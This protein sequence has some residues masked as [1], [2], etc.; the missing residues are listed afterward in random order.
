MKKR[1]FE[2]IYTRPQFHWRLTL[3]VVGLTA[4]GSLFTKCNAQDRYL[5]YIGVG[6]TLN[7][8]DSSTN[9]ITKKVGY[10]LHFGSAGVISDHFQFGGELQ[11]TNQRERSTNNKIKTNS[12]AGLLYFKYLPFKD[13]GFFVLIGP[14]IGMIVNEKPESE[15]EELDPMML[16][17]VFGLGYNMG[18]FNLDI[19]QNIPLS[20]QIMKSYTQIGVSFRLNK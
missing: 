13:Q 2:S 9:E 8:I 18:R 15:K 5:N 14:R 11:F 16:T 17:S 19:R 12:I 7:S 1:R 4:I 10:Y 20:K 6:M 3:I